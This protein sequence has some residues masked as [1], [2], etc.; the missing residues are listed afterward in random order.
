MS[1]F[2]S[3][4]YSLPSFIVRCDAVQLK[5]SEQQIFSFNWW[6]WTRPGE[7]TGIRSLTAPFTNTIDET[8][9][10]GWNVPSHQIITKITHS[11]NRT[12]KRKLSN[13]ILFICSNQKIDYFFTH[14]SSMAVNEIET[15][16]RMKMICCCVDGFSIYFSNFIISSFS[17]R[18]LLPLCGKWVFCAVKC[19]WCKINWWFS[20]S[21]HTVTCISERHRWATRCNRFIHRDDSG[22]RSYF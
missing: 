7:A 11:I 3:S 15:I 9:S 6:N 13:I 10:P 2:S 19:E 22:Q 14:H 18:L 12:N 21:Q 20:F 1:F 5:M 8:V 16:G 17:I 4:L